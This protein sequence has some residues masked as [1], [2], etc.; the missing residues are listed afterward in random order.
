M[1]VFCGCIVSACLSACTFPSPEEDGYYIED[2]NSKN[3]T[4]VN[5]VLLH[6]QEKALLSPGMEIAF[7][8]EKYIFYEKE[9]Q[10]V[11]IV[12]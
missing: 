9:I 1:R 11:D 4:R 6:Y 2:L 3:G 12:K 8:G 10:S 5:G 7:A